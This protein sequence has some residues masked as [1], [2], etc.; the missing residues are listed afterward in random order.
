MDTLSQ[1]MMMGAA[2]GEDPMRLVVDTSIHTSYA[3]FFWNPVNVL[4]DWGDGSTDTLVNASGSGSTSK[5]HT[6]SSAA[7]YTIKVTGKAYGLGQSGL[8]VLNQSALTK[9]LSFGDLGFVKMSGG[10]IYNT[11]LNEVPEAIPPAVTDLSLLFYDASSF[12]QDISMW[13]TA[14]VT[15]MNEMFYDASSFNQ[16]LS[17]WITGVAS[18]PLNFSTGSSATFSNNANGLKPYLSD[19][20]TQINT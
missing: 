13:E 6:W 4:I 10:F 20:V 19:G 7:E 18:Q 17:S 12:N 16:D 14:N 3:I 1:R 2:G 15:N 8:V 9:C 5:S 11:S